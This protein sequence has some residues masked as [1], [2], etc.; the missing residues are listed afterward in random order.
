MPNGDVLLTDENNLCLKRMTRNGILSRVDLPIV[1]TDVCKIGMV[2]PYY[3]SHAT[4]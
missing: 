4:N 1:P 3:T 2:K